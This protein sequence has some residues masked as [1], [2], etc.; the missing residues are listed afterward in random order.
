MTYTG[1]CR[2]GAVRFTAR[3][4][5]IWRSYCHCDHCRKATGAPVAAFVGFPAAKVAFEGEAPRSFRAGPVERSFCGGCG[6]P[7]DYRDDR[8][9]GEVYFNLGV[10]DEPER[11]APKLHAFESCRLPFL[12]IDDDLPRFERFSIE[13]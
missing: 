2:C 12:R 3:A 6:S 13:R 8:L 4:E 11:F 10:M 9:P 5:S 7:L 1:G